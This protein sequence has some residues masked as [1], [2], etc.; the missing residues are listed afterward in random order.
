[1]AEQGWQGDALATGGGP[2]QVL[3]CN[4]PQPPPPPPRVLKDSGAGSATDKCP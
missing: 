3:V 1:M 4:T 2:G